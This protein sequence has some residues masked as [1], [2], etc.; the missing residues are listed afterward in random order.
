M[1]DSGKDK[2]ATE[3][4]SKVIPWISV[5]SIG[6][7]IS[8]GWLWILFQT[9][10]AD[11]YL[12]TEAAF[13]LGT[14]ARIVS[15]VVMAISLALIGLLS[16]K[17]KIAE[18]CIPVMLVVG[19]VSGPIGMALIWVSAFIGG[20]IE[21][22]CI[23]GWCL[24]AV[25]AACMLCIWA[26]ALVGFRL[27]VRRIACI[28]AA[29]VIA[30]ALFLIVGFLEIPIALCIIMIL[31]ICSGLLFRMNKSH[32][33]ELVTSRSA[34]PK[35]VPSVKLVVAMGI[36]GFAF[37]TL[38]G[39]GLP[40]DDIS[41]NQ[42]A[43][44]IV[45]VFSLCMLMYAR[46]SK[47]HGIS[48]AYRVAPVVLI[49]AFLLLPFL[50]EL[51]NYWSGVLGGSGY[52]IYEILLLMVVFDSIVRFQLR[53][54]PA[55]AV[56]RCA[57]VCGL[58]FGWVFSI[59]F[60]N[61]F[62]LDSLGVAAFSSITVLVLVLANAL[63]IDEKALFI[64]DI[65]YSPKNS[66]VDTKGDLPRLVEYDRLE[67]RCLEIARNYH[68]TNREEE[69]LALLARGRNARY[70]QDVLV[71]T[72][73]TAKAHRYNIYKKLDIHSHQELIDLIEAWP[74]MKHTM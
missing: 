6:F 34:H 24:I 62:P 16:R 69:V 44:A 54:I 70:I 37:G 68:L 60:F 4:G 2:T 30:V 14:L 27:A 15:L 5:T 38:W 20:A 7:G 52:L 48:L 49:A 36:F 51:R 1:H 41:S 64:A 28:S 67:T 39:T 13:P 61:A 73:A 74:Q 65:F 31:P 9:P 33:G 35:G 26:T 8:L 57:T 43:F 25:C 46:F 42:L 63:L 50:G 59:A 18:R 58:C 19:M 21:V 23:A 10:F 11:H 71:V 32:L 56:A 53:T 55:F 40:K 72:N 29:A 45:G 3:R 17:E 66:K 47:S 12:D 22:L